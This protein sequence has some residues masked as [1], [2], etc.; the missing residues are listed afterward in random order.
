MRVLLSIHLYPPF[1]NCGGETYVH[2]AAKYL[3]TKGHEVRV[4]IF[5]A[6]D[7]GINQLYEWEGVTVF[8]PRNTEDSLVQWADIVLTHLGFTQQS[9]NKAAEFG[10]PIVYVSHNTM[11]DSYDCVKDNPHVGVVYNCEAMRG[12]SPFKDNPAMVLHPYIDHAKYYVNLNPDKSQFITMINCNENK[13]GKIF[14]KLAAA[15]PDRQ[16]MAVKGSYEEQFIAD[17]PN[18]TI[19]DNSPDILPVYAQTR[20]LLMLSRYESWGMTATEAMINGIPVICCPTFGLLENCGEAGIYLPA[21]EPEIVDSS[22]NL[23]GEDD[24]DTYDIKAIISAIKALDNKKKYKEVSEQC[25]KQ[26]QKI[27]PEKELNA[28]EQ[29][30]LSLIHGG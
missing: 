16:F 6:S 4:I 8:P 18:V 14:G 11:Y 3:I 5:Q 20:V 2:N 24:G 1:H 28:F 26:V 15:M 12:Q 13:G 19:R 10:K 9:I 22:G 23:T 29:F 25:K 27:D 17:L 30:L 21:R 7:H